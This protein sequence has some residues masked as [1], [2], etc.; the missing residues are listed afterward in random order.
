MPRP[1]SRALVLASAPIHIP[2][3]AGKDELEDYRRRIEQALSDLSDCAERLA[4]R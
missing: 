2:E 1:F 4:S 3:K